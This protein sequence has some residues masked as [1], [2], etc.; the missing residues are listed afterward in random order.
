MKPLA[1]HRWLNLA[2]PPIALFAASLMLWRAT[3]A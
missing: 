3:D 1:G 2:L